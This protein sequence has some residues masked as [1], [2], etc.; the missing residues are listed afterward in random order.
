MANAPFACLL[1]H[2]DGGYLQIGEDG[3]VFAW[4]APFF[5]SLGGMP[6]NAPIVDAAWTPTHQGYWMV[7]ADGGVFNFGDAQFHGSMGG[8]ALNEPIKSIAATGEGGYIL[9]ARDGGVFPFGPGAVYE[10]NALWSG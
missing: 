6:I 2:P 9:A 7:G 8:A 5:G 10:G 4:E 1:T 3:G